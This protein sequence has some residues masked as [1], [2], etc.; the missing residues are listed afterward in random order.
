MSC[1]SITLIHQCKA[2][3]ARQ[4]QNFTFSS[5]GNHCIMDTWRPG[6]L[7]CKLKAVGT[8]LLALFPG[9]SHLQYLNACSANTEGEGL[10]DLVMCGYVR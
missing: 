9:R 7:Y 1:Q 10:G 4:Y 8:K 6:S 2:P 3:M 5:S